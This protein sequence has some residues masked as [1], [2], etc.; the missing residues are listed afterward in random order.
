MLAKALAEAPLPTAETLTKAPLLKAAE[1]NPTKP[2]PAAAL[3]A[4]DAPTAAVDAT[5]PTIKEATMSNSTLRQLMPPR[6]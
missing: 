4:A 6:I 5:A 2:V 3:A 1:L